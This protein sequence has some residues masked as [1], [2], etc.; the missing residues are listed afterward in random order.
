MKLI[1][2]AIR[3]PQCSGRRLS[4]ERFELGNTSKTAL[5]GR[6][7]KFVVRFPSESSTYLRGSHDGFYPC[8]TRSCFHVFCKTPSSSRCCKTL[9]DSSATH[10][11]AQETFALKI[12]HTPH[13]PGDDV[14]SST[15]CT[16]A[17]DLSHSVRPI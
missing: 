9:T 8:M 13:G 2:R 15:V 16:D 11:E 5:R 7:T 14:S 10:A 17:F 6:I 4:D 12:S 3:D 1:K